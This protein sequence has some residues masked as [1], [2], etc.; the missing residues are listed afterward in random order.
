MGEQERLRAGLQTV[1]T[2][3]ALTSRFGTFND[4][5]WDRFIEELS[6][7]GFDADRARPAVDLEA[8]RSRRIDGGIRIRKGAM[9]YALEAA[10]EEATEP[11]G[12]P[13][14]GIEM[15]DIAKLA[16]AVLNHLPEAI[17][18]AA[19]QAKDAP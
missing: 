2:V 13:A 16:D 12:D 18:R 19:L 15:H 14:D 9:E 7:A 3:K 17:E 5:W 10:W 8:L 1:P 6:V 4:A 11:V